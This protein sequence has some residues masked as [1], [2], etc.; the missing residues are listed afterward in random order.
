MVQ[1]PTLP[2]GFSDT[3]RKRF[4]RR[5]NKNGFIPIHAQHL[6]KCWEWTGYKHPSGYGSIGK[7][8]GES[9]NIP[10]S[11]AAFILAN[12]GRDIPE[13]LYVLHKCDNPGCVNPDH[14]FIG[15]AKDNSIDCNK[16]GRGNQPRG[17]RHR[18]AKLTEAEVIEIRR[19]F[20]C[21]I[22]RPYKLAQM[23]GVTPQTIESVLNGKT[24]VFVTDDQE[25]DLTPI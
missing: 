21:K 2:Q 15:T 4:E 6:G 22:H 14:L 12:G 13:G 19:L 17:E 8:G 23:F 7:G 11:R 5:V 16:K 9:G 25:V 10:A 3:F 20:Y 18:C 1:D 24:W